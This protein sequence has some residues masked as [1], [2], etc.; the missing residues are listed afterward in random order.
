MLP[1]LLF[2]ASAREMSQCRLLY[3]QASKQRAD[4]KL[5]KSVCDDFELMRLC[6]RASEQTKVI[7]AL[8]RNLGL[9]SRWQSWQTMDET[10]DAMNMN[11][12]VEGLRWSSS[13]LNSQTVLVNTVSTHFASGAPGWRP[14]DHTR[15]NCAGRA[16]SLSL[17]LAN[18]GQ[19]F[20]DV[21]VG[22][23]RARGRRS[24][25]ASVRFGRSAACRVA[26]AA[27]APASAPY[28]FCPRRT[29]PSR[30]AFPALGWHAQTEGHPQ[31]TTPL[32]G[33]SGIAHTDIEFTDLA[34]K[35]EVCPCWWQAIK[36]RRWPAI[37]L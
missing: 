23:R 17:A 5:G 29:S 31:L 3:K 2:L 27:A 16:L 9:D 24:G 13:K 7:S 14:L 32:T 33:T 19:R 37:E 36:V 28:F 30:A 21:W 35:C 34:R 1:F 8:L 10:N 4:Q 20:A 22:A 26:R 25:G 11:P 18:A 15:P 12:F 6:W